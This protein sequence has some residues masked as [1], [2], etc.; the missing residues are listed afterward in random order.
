M[1]TPD[2][3]WLP[4]TCALAVAAVGLLLGPAVR[5]SPD[6]LEMLALAGCWAGGSCDGLLQGYWPPLWPALMVP[7]VGFDGEWAGRTVNVVCAA[8]V[9][10]PLWRTTAIAAGERAER[11]ISGAV[12]AGVWV[13]LPMVS[14]HAVVL[15]ARPLAW[16]LWAGGAWGAAEAVSGR[17]WGWG[18]AGV[19]GALAPLA[20]PEGLA[21]PVGLAVFAALRGGGLR[22]AG[23]LLLG[24]LLPKAAW[25]A[26]MPENRGTVEAF[27]GPWFGVWPLD[28]LLTL[29]GPAS[30]PSG[31]RQFALDT[32]AAG[33]VEAPRDVGGL[34]VA[35]T[36]ALARAPVGIVGVGGGLLALL[37]IGRSFAAL[38]SPAGRLPAVL[39]LGV[40]VA[41]SA[42]PMAGGQ[43]S[44]ATNYLFLLPLGLVAAF[45]MP[46]RRPSDPRWLALVPLLVLLEAHFSP[47][48]EPPADFLLDTPSAK[49]A[50]EVIRHDATLDGATIHAGFEGRGILRRAGR[51]PLL[52]PSTWEHFDPQPGAYVL[53]VAHGLLEAGRALEVAEDPRAQLCW[54]YEGG[55]LERLSTPAF[56]APPTL[57]WVALYRWDA[58]C[59]E[60]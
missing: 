37:A 60:P 20:R 44:P 13:L 10:A 56:E 15:D 22:T 38:R 41:L 7:F 1:P 25:S 51:P 29:Y 47:V 28:D 45:R 36:G 3:P 46:V 5:L 23:A 14:D 42:A 48:R 12:A 19:C 43:A 26:L 30:L 18:V 50:A 2:R 53:L 6:G 24:G 4:E 55:L 16:L 58:A 33:D 40:L 49:G 27:F 11:S 21:L 59:P 39:G 31:Y 57:D 54:V 52:L 32:L 9:V 8:L 34:L 35:V 17:R